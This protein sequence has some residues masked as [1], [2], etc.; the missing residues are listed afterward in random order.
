MKFDVYFP[1][2]NRAGA[3]CPGVKPCPKTWAE[4][5][6]L[7]KEQNTVSTI[8]R[9]RNG[10]KD[11]KKLL[12]AICFTGRCTGTRR[13]ASLMKPTQLVMLDI[14]HCNEPVQAWNGIRF[15]IES[16]AVDSR[17]GIEDVIVAHVTPSGKG[18]RLVVRCVN[19]DLHTLNEQMTWWIEQLSLSLHGDP[20]LAVKDFGRLSFLPQHTDLL[21]ESVRLSLNVEL[22]EEEVLLND[23]LPENDKETS[24]VDKAPKA[25]NTAVFTDEEREC[26]ETFMY[27]GTPLKTIIAKYLEVYGE[28]DSGEKHSFYNE[29][30]KNFRTICDNNKRLLLYSLPRF[31]HSLE[32]CESQI[33][34]ICKVNTL[35]SIPKQ[36]YF[37]L[38]DNGFYKK[39]ELSGN[40]FKEYMLSEE[41]VKRVDP[42]YLPPIIKDLI[43]TAPADFV[44]PTLNGLL[45]ILGTLTSYVEA[46]FP[47]DNRMHTTSFFSIIYAPPGTGKG[48]IERF[49]DLLFKDLKIRD[50][51]QSARENIYLRTI[52]QKGSNDKSPDLP[53]TSLR[54]IPAKNSEPEFLQKQLD[55]QGYH[56]FTYAAE[57]DSWAKGAKAAGGNKD[58]MIRIAWD[59]G[60]YGQQ[61]KS[62]NTFKGIVRL[63]W[64][65]LICGTLQQ[66]ENYFKNVE[67]GLVTR[68]SFFSIDNQEFAEP[69]VWKT[70]NKKSLE[71]I[72]R[73]LKRCDENTYETPCN[74][75]PEDLVGI[76]DE[77]FDQTVDWKFKFRKRKV[78]NMDWIMPAIDNFHKRQIARATLDQDHARDVFRRRVAV[79][80][81]RLGM[82][83]YCLWENPRPSDLARCIPFIEWWMERDLD[84]MLKLWGEKYNSIADT[85]PSMVQRNVY[86]SLKEEFD[87]QDIYNVCVAQGVKTPVRRILFDWKKLGRIEK[88]GKNNYKKVNNDKVSSKGKGKSRSVAGSKTESTAD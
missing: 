39:R 87:T 13:M 43:S 67:N 10:D 83:C 49:M 84:S 78:I 4:I 52:Q 44:L 38:K 24:V 64:N 12:P 18:L 16:G 56:M 79:R 69:A 29:M 14:D 57:M 32:E 37:F 86:S 80:G 76:K 59:N 20:D 35:S 66:I 81:F 11:A 40:A 6:E 51:V 54:I 82:I 1:F 2:R 33:R 28:P 85:T 68:C 21:H 34:S 25:E 23:T 47:Y 17:I 9:V 65:V 70:L 7:M 63:Y 8:A 62:A 53:H 19:K 27:K 22:E 46:R 15:K 74:I 31:G 48:N 58:D 50:Y 26:F 30:V 5:C 3:V 72:N 71:R 42:P 45:P 77:D 36:F 61:F 75:F 41:E 60:E 55:N 88:I 73:F